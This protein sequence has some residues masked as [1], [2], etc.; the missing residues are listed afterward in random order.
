MID[1]IVYRREWKHDLWKLGKGFIKLNV[2]QDGIRENIPDYV[3]LPPAAPGN[4]KRDQRT[5][6]EE[7]STIGASGRT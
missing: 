7:N 2:V 5:S 3:E 1:Q 6:P 4:N